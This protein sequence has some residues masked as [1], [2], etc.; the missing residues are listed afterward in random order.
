M[1]DPCTFWRHMFQVSGWGNEA[2][3]QHQEGKN[4]LVGPGRAQGMTSKGLRGADEGWTVSKDIFDD[5]D[6]HRI[7]EARTTPVWVNVVNAANPLLDC[8]AQGLLQRRFEPF[9]GR[10]E[11]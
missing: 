6:L 8:L 10:L 4:R 1:S 2:V 11:H 9:T 5:L 7:M 3:A